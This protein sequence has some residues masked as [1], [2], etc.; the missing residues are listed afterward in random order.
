MS[1]ANVAVTVRIPATW[2]SPQE[3][4]SAMP[5]DC[6][7][8]PDRLIFSDGSEFELDL[9]DPDDQFA[10]LFSSMCRRE[11]TD[12]E[13]RQI[14]N[15]TVQLCL[16]ARGGSMELAA[17]LMHATS[18]VLRAG[19]AGVFVDNSGV[20]M[21]GSDWQMLTEEGCGDTLN[22]DAISFAFVGIIGG[23]EKMYTTGMHILGLPDLLLVTTDMES[24]GDQLIEMMQYLCTTERTVDDGHIIADENGP[25]YQVQMTPDPNAKAHPM[26]NPW[27]RLQLIS[28]KD[29]AQ[30]N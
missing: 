27:G 21:G 3:M 16:T 20:A 22:P 24:H 11:P 25:R 10:G 17:K 13:K 18:V 9:R 1:N 15:Y 6:R 23:A 12:E 29:I 14:E 8:T 7:F 2:A 4:V 26:Y 30:Q 5:S 28:I 19:G